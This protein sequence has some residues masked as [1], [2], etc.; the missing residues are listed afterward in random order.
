MNQCPDGTGFTSCNRARRSLYRKIKICRHRRPALAS[1]AV[2]R[3]TR[4]WEHGKELVRRTW[5]RKVDRT[6]GQRWN[7]DHPSPDGAATGYAVLTSQSSS[8]GDSRDAI[9]QPTA[10]PQ[11]R[12]TPQPTASN[13]VRAVQVPAA[14]QRV[15]KTRTSV[16]E[17]DIEIGTVLET[18]I[19]QDKRYENNP[20]GVGCYRWFSEGS[21]NPKTNTFHAAGKALSGLMRASDN[22]R[23]PQQ[24]PALSTQVG[25]C[26]TPGMTLIHDVISAV[27]SFGTSSIRPPVSPSLPIH[28]SEESRC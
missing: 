5:R 20:V 1:M 23:I 7:D 21:W 13:Q 24:L 16:D 9:P 2:S 10:I 15:E 4:M 27:C 28:A 3:A 11:P 22:T 12:D 6:L 19:T 18:T 26:E 17:A 25:F 8:T 14:D